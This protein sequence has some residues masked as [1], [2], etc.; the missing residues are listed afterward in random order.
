MKKILA[1]FLAAL[2]VAGAAACGGGKG[3]AETSGAV[4][5]SEKTEDMFASLSEYDGYK[6]G[7][8][9]ETYLILNSKIPTIEDGNGLDFEGEISDDGA[10]PS[11]I[12]R[13]TVAVEDR[14]EVDVDHVA[15]ETLVEDIYEMTQSGDADYQAIYGVY[16]NMA[17]V[18]MAGELMNLRDLPCINYGAEWWNASAQENLTVGGNQYFAINDIAYTTLMSTHCMFFNLKLAEDYR[19]KV[20]NPYEYVENGTWTLDRLLQTSK[21]VSLDNGD[22]V[23]DETD[24]YGLALSIGSSTMFGVSF[25]ESVYPV[26]IVNGE[27][28]EVD[29]IKWADIVSRLYTL[30]YDND[31]GTYVGEHLSSTATSIFVNGGALY[32][33]GALCEAPSYFR[34]MTDDFGVLPMPKYDE[35][36]K[37]YR[38][39]LSGGSA[40][41]G[42]SRLHF[43]SDNTFIGFVTEALA[44]ASGRYIRS[45]VYETVFENQ[46]TRD[47]E[48]KKTLEIIENSIFADFVFLHAGGINGYYGEIHMLLGQKMDQ[49]ASMRK[50]YKTK[51]E[52][53]YRDVIESYHNIA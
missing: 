2:T 28:A 42:T 19:A 36:Q 11:A 24:Q 9:G 48:S 5:E 14:F 45:A 46:I 7:L 1:L 35:K 39:P 44:I 23:W 40:V 17:T 12:Y 52:G 29:E 25:G 10:I 38:T 37:D 20:G 26:K 4:S 22:S 32:Y 16:S 30:F 8:G 31:N 33:V 34:D 50:R 27:V 51:V 43:N 49:Y 21:G 53:Y 15:T 47:E 3:P 13:R 18:A 41:F 6:N